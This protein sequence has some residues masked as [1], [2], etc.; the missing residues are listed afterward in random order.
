MNSATTIFGLV[1]AILIGALFHLWKDGGFWRLVLYLFSSILGF[2]LGHWLADSFNLN[3]L[4]VG[5]LRLFGAV[6][7][8]ILF[9]F[10]INWLGRDAQTQVRR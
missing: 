2:F 8:S 7:G 1:I 3:L 6:A 10:L 9:L 4:N 5:G